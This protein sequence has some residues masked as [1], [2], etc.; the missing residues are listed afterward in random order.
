M[1]QV[2]GDHGVLSARANVDAAM[3]RR[4]AWRRRQRKGV[5]ELVGII[6]QQGLP[7]LDDWSAIVAPDIARRIGATRGGGLPIGVFRSEEHTSELQSLRHLVC[8]LLLEK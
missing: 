6:N 3:V 4:M 7:G 8:R 2:A 1:H 5:V